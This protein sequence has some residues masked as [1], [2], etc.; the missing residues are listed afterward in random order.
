M[1]V[2]GLCRKVSDSWREHTSHQH[3]TV[4]THTDGIS[5]STFHCGKC[6]STFNNRWLWLDHIEV[7]H[8][9]G[10]NFLQLLN[11]VTDPY[12]ATPKIEGLMSYATSLEDAQID[13]YY[14][15]TYPGWVRAE[16]A[17]ARP[18]RPAFGDGDPR[19]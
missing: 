2:C 11:M 16:D 13:L 5:R 4:S 19:I 8:R 14:D 9:Q 18:Q 3:E 17:D 1:W 7:M 12:V 6:Q 10:P 15:H